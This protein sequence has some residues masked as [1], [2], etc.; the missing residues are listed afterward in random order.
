MG[1]LSAECDSLRTP[2]SN[3][4]PRRVATSWGIECKNESELQEKQTNELVT[5]EKKSV[6]SMRLSV[7]SGCVNVARY[8]FLAPR[9]GRDGS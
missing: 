4:D 5:I 6:T 8:R 9:R 3:G 7:S 1:M 2:I